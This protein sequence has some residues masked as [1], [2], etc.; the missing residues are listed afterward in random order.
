MILKPDELYTNELFEDYIAADYTVKGY[1]GYLKISNEILSAAQT[2]GTESK[3]A[4]IT[5][6]MWW[7]TPDGVIVHSDVTRTIHIK[8]NTVD[9]IYFT[10]NDPTLTTVGGG[11]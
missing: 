1:L 6:G 8:N 5:V 11:N 9:G 7:K 2:N 3:P 4:E 10:D